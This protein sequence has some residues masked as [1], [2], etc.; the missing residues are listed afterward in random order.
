[1][2]L[3]MDLRFTETAA[4]LF[5]D[6]EAD[7]CNAL[8]VVST[9]HTTPPENQ[10][11]LN[12][13]KREREDS[14]TDTPR[15][16]KPMKAAHST[17][18]PDMSRHSMSRAPSTL[19]PRSS[20]SLSTPHAS[21]PPP[22]TPQAREPLFLPASS[23]DPGPSQAVRQDT[24]DDDFDMDNDDLNLMQF[25]PTQGDPPAEAVPKVSLYRTI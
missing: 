24:F 3:P 7:N 18:N 13:R 11:I 1:M 8:F 5:M 20:R 9:G 12:P 10:V 25:S 6:V 17:Q 2:S 19:P 23:Q 21:F 15:F 16:K 22:P 4:P 14:Q